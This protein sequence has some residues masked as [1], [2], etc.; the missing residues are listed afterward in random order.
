[1][2]PRA[3][4]V[5]AGGKPGDSVMMLCGWPDCASK[6]SLRSMTVYNL[7]KK[8]PPLKMFDDVCCLVSWRCGCV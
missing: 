2:H 6:H 4:E 8:V 1:M 7:T 5:A 3:G